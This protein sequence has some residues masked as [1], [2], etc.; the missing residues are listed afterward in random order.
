M[1]NQT[2]RIKYCLFS[3]PVTSDDNELVVEALYASHIVGI[4]K[5]LA[6]PPAR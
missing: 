6:H 5:L 1:D 3:I 2:K 4:S